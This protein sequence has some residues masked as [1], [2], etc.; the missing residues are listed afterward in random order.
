MIDSDYATGS[1]V[2]NIATAVADEE[3]GIVIKV[4]PGDTVTVA[5]T[6]AN[7]AAITQTQANAL[8]AA[9]YASIASTNG[10]VTLA[11]P[12]LLSCWATA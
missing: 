11:S 4:P 5:D 3:A 9:G 7:I 2:L 1:V 6:A 12:R 10:A 8:K